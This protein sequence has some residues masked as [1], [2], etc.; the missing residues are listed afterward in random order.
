MP[1]PEMFNDT[2]L[3][4]YRGHLEPTDIRVGHVVGSELP[5]KL[6]LAQPVGMQIKHA[7]ATPPQGAML[8]LDMTAETAAHLV[9]EIRR[10]FREMGWPLNESIGQSSGGQRQVYANP[11]PGK[12]RQP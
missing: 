5:V 10:L 6:S 7:L 2:F 12:K 3:E 1:T 4:S 8:E 9:G 11:K